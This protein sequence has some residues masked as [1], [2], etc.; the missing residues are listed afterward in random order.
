VRCGYE[1]EYKTNIRRHFYVNKTQCPGEKNNIELTEDILEDILKTVGTIHPK[2]NRS[3]IF[4]TITI[5]STNSFSKRISLPRRTIH[6]ANT[7]I[8]NC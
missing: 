4:T 1:T 7:K 2:I 3:R 6:W 5:S 8:K